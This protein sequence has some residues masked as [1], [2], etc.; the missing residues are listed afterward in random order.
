VSY[1]KYKPVTEAHV[2]AYAVLH[3][4]HD[5]HAAT[6]TVARPGEP[7]QALFQTR[8]VRLTSPNDEL[9]GMLFLAT[10]QVT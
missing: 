2:R 7:E 1:F 9:G 4:T 10:P 5:P 8:S 6:G 3:E